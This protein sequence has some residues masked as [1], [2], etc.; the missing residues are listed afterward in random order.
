ME[1]EIGRRV[2]VNFAAFTGGA[3]RSVESVPC[4]VVDVREG[5]SLVRTAYPY[6]SFSLWVS[7]FWIEDLGNPVSQS[8][9]LLRG[10]GENA[11]ESLA[12]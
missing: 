4:E 12:G 3:R 10:T 2:R 9:R 8:P 6:R 11:E 7:N 5:Q 1:I